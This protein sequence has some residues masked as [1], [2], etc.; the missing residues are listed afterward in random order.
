MQLQ[1]DTQQ[2][3][4]NPTSMHYLATATHRENTMHFFLLKSD[5]YNNN[6]SK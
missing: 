1:R 2:I 4:L 3:A 5:R 6:P